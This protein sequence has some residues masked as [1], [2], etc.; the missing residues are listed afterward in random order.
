MARVQQWDAAAKQWSLI[1][2]FMERDQ[3]ILAPLIAED[4]EAFAKEAGITP[5]ACN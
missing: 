2:E 1:T 3:E 4:S 5:R